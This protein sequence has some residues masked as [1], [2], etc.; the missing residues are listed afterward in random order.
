MLTGHSRFNTMLA[1][2]RK[3]TLPGMYDIHT[4]TMQYPSIAQPTHARWERVDV[5]SNMK[6]ITNGMNGHNINSNEVTVMPKL[7]SVY[8]RNIRIHDLCLESAPDSSLGPPGLDEDPT[9]LT[10]VPQDV[11]DELPPECRAAFD[12]AKNRQI[13]WKSKWL[14]EATDGMRARFTPSMNWTG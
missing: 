6:A 8:G 2:I 7:E 4:N 11:L 12:E 5:E 3:D 14:T 13:E 9:S 10:S 1:G